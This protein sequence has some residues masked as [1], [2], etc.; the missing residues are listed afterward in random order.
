VQINGFAINLT[1]DNPDRLK[2]FYGG[3]VGLE[4]RSDMGDGAFAVGPGTLFVDGHSD[5]KGA[6]KEPQRVLI[7]LFVDDLAAAQKPLDA[8]GVPCVRNAGR[9]EWG[10][11][12]STF[13]DPDGNYLQLIEF[14][15]Q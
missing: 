3:T 2:A 4:R 12:I 11:V 9:E 8:A 5:T 10:G 14:K 15:G 13:A 1:S 6:A 7:N